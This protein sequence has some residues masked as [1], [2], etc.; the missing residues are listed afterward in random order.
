MHRVYL[1]E[2]GEV[3]RLPL[4][5][6]LMVL[7]TLKDAAAV[8][9]AQ[10]LISRAQAEVTGQESRVIIDMVATIIWYQFEQLSRSEIEAMLDIPVK[11]T[12]LYQEG[13]QESEANIIL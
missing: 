13:R 2:I 6:G 9:D 3:E 7:T 8:T 10:S 11:E 1:D 12:R 5:V 4:W